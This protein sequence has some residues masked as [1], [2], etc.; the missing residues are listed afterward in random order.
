MINKRIKQLKEASENDD[1]TSDLFK[2]ET[3]NWNSLSNDSCNSLTE[4]QRGVFENIYSFYGCLI[5]A[6][7]RTYAI[8]SKQENGIQIETDEINESVE[9]Y[10]SLL[11]FAK[12]IENLSN[13][14]IQRVVVKLQSELVA[15]C[16]SYSYIFK[17][18]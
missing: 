17:V 9:C 18:F 1:F 6:L 11:H 8:K 4:V 14:L 3:N 7:Q 5:C 10:N 2:C 15:I 13:L 12:N 16:F